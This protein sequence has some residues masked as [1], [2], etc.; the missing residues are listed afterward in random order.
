MSKSAGTNLAEIVFSFVVRIP[1]EHCT[2]AGT[3]KPG[4]EFYPFQGKRGQGHD[5]LH[6]VRSRLVVRAVTNA[7]TAHNA[8]K[9]ASPPPM[10]LGQL[11]LLVF[12]AVK[13]TVRALPVSVCRTCAKA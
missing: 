6:A 9:P 8:A 12:A 11:T 10:R 5:V 4:S 1:G 13:L 2:R 3:V 7:T